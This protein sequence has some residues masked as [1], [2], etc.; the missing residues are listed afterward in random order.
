MPGSRSAASN[1]PAMLLSGEPIVPNVEHGDSVL[2]QWT[3]AYWQPSPESPLHTIVDRIWYFDGTLAVARERVFPDGLVEIVVQIDEPHRN[4][5]LSVPS[6]FPSVCVNGVRTGPNVVIAPARR[7]RV[8]G[9]R[10]HAA[11]AS[12]VVGVPARVLCDATFDLD[13][14][15]GGATRELGGRCFDAAESCAGAP[16]QA[17]AVVRTAADWVTRRISAAPEVSAVAF[18]ASIIVRDRGAVRIQALCADT[19]LARP[20]LARRFR[21][22]IGITPKRFARIVRFQHTLRALNDGAAPSAAAFDLA[23]F[24]QAHLHRDFEEFARMTPG[25]FLATTRYAGS[26]SVAES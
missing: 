7:C 24:D 15:A 13:D 11:S 26:T 4:G 12:A 17:A 23:Y 19:G 9:I 6:P 22:E 20:E 3:A 21:S 1:T 2:G 5:D 25:E 8:A 10:L 18:V 16:A 14:V